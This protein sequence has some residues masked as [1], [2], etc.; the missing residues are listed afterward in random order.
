MNYVE[1]QI[2]L[3]TDNAPKIIEHTGFL[4]HLDLQLCVLRSM[5]SKIN[6]LTPPDTKLNF[7]IKVIKS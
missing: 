2:K 7:E 4:H 5:I 3:I 1:Q 6:K